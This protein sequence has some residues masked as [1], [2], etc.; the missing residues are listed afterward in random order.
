[1]AL[2]KVDLADTVARNSTFAGDHAHQIADLNAI[3]SSDRHEKTRHA[4]GGSPGS[5]GICWSWLRR[6]SSIL[7]CRASLGTFALEQIERRG[8][9]LRGVELL[10]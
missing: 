7:S 8:R 9:E 1:M 10:E 6:W 2:A 4:A 5:I 3:P